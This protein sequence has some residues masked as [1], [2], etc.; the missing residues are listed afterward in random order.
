MPDA[1]GAFGVID[2][3][4]LRALRD[5][6]VR[7]FGLADIAIDAFVGNDECHGWDFPAGRPAGG[8]YLR[9]WC[10]TLSESLA[11][12]IGCTNADTSPPNF[13]IS[14]TI[15]AETNMYCSDGV[16]NSVSTSG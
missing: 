9:D 5:R 6:A 13:A 15:V 12:T 8:I 10:A 7:A 14:R 3:I 16:R 2:D 4:D 1:F 11:R